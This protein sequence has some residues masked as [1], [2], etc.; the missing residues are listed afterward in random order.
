MT[1]IYSWRYPSEYNSLN[2]FGRLE[3]QLYRSD[4]AGST[5]VG[6]LQ[7]SIRAVCQSLTPS[8]VTQLGSGL[9]PSLQA[10]ELKDP[11][12]KLFVDNQLNNTAP[13][14]KKSD[15]PTSGGVSGSD[16]R[17]A[18]CS[19]VGVRADPLLTPV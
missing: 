13:D 5:E 2:G 10:K 15:P 19:T 9:L 17:S 16:L 1:P 18:G 11:A 12:E 6:R 3:V 14:V 8:G 4:M 7:P